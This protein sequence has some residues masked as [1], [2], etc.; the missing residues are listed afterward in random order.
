[1]ALERLPSSATPADVA[2]ALGRN[3]YAIVERIVAPAVLDRARTELAPYLDATPY[4]PDDFA[5]R[6]TRRTGG[7]IAR[8]ATC[9]DL[10]RNPLVLGA[11]GE[12]LK[13]VTSFQLH[14]TQVIAIGP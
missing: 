3:G 8:S 6:R 11:V 1:M 13:H 2:A 7:L 4:G 12:V 9:R 5:G 14:L 10:V